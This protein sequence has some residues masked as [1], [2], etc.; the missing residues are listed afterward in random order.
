MFDKMVFKGVI[1]ARDEAAIVSEWN[2]MPCTKDGELYYQSSEI[3]KIEG[4]F[5][6]IRGCRI[7]IKCSIH[8]LWSKWSGHGLDN[9]RD[10]SVADAQQ[11]IMRLFDSL[12][13]I[14]R[15]SVRV[16]Y[17]EVG[18]NMKMDHS[19]MEY[20]RA[21]FGVGDV[22]A[23]EMFIDANFEK[24]RQKTTIKN[25]NIRKVLKIY[26]KTFEAES[27][28]R[29]GTEEDILR[30]E[31]IYK[32]QGAHYDEFFDPVFIHKIMRTFYRDWS[33]LAFQRIVVADKGIRASQL[34]KAK[35]IIRYGT[36]GY[37][38]RLKARY[39]EGAITPRMLRDGKEFARDWYKNRD[40]FR[41]IAS[42]MEIE[43]QH[44]LLDKFMLNQNDMPISAH[45]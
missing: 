36:E 35:S 34:D 12:G 29:T 14:D 25:H 31:T 18:L 10:C 11:T 37:L 44:K 30:V 33:Q 15:Q 21:V 28:R 32:R 24:N 16:T 6:M 41:T 5:I 3:W 17:Y 19:P 39:N 26:D 22:G 20:I 13:N 1:D 8:K 2:L 27:K 42:D 7:E 9:S 4:V 43:Y 45:Y 40:R 38:E 23:R